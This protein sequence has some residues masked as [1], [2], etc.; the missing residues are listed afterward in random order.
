M[1][2]IV[3]DKLPPLHHVYVITRPIQYHRGVCYSQRYCSWVRKRFTGVQACSSD[4]VD[5][6]KSELMQVR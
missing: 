3:S 2:H 1:C 5:T 4:C 6:Y